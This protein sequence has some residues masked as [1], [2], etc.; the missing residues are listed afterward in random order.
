MDI[1]ARDQ[2]D[3]EEGRRG[4]GLQKEKGIDCFHWAFCSKIAF[5]AA[6][7][8]SKEEGNFSKIFGHEFTPRIKSRRT[9]GEIPPRPCAFGEVDTF[10]N[11]GENF[12]RFVNE[13]SEVDSGVK[14]EE[15][16]ESSLWKRI[17][18]RACVFPGFSTRISKVLSN[19]NGRGLDSTSNRE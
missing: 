19:W 1:E 5:R 14:L 16:M 8:R 4:V 2:R 18:H 3:F 17:R 10:A 12:H 7:G 9:G 6:A 11:A 13:W 15:A